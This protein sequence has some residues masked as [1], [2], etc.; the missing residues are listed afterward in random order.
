MKRQNFYSL[1]LRA[2]A[3]ALLMGGVGLTAN[4]QDLVNETAGKIQNTG[5][6]KFKN[7]GAKFTN[8]ATVSNHTMDDG[9][10]EFNGASAVYD[11]SQALGSNATTNRFPGLVRW[12]GTGAQDLNAIAAGSEYYTDLELASAGAKSVPDAVYVGGT[13]NVVAA[14]GD[15]TYAGTFYY[16]GA[17]QR[18]FPEVGASGTTNQYNN[19]NLQGTGL[20]SLN[21]GDNIAL[22][23]TLENVA[24]APL[25]IGGQLTIGTTATMADVV[26]I[27]SANVAALTTSGTGLATFNANL[28]LEQGN[29]NV[30]A[31]GATIST[32]ATLAVA[33]DAEAKLNVAAASDLTIT[34]TFTNAFAAATNLNFNATS[35]TIYNGA[36]SQAIVATV[37]TN[38]YGNLTT[39]N[40]GKT[41]AGTSDNDIYVA[42]DL[43]VNGGDLDVLTGDHELFMTDGGASYGA[44]GYEVRGK[45][46]RDGS[47][48]DNTTLL[49]SATAYT[50]NNPKTI[51]QFASG[52]M[53]ESF[54]IDARAGTAPFAYDNTTDIN[55]KIVTS[56]TG[57]STDWSASIQAGYKSSDIPGTW[58]PTTTEATLRYMES[59][60]DGAPVIEKLATGQTYTREQAGPDFNSITLAGIMPT[61]DAIDGNSDK[62][63]KS[64]NDLLLRGGPT[65]FYAVSSG[66]WSNPG[67]WDEGE[68]P[69]ATDIAV[70]NGYTVHAGFAGRSDGG[71]AAG[72]NAEQHPDNLAAGI[73]IGGM[74]STPTQ[75]GS[76]LIF[77]EVDAQASRVA[78]FSMNALGTITNKAGSG[79]A[80]IADL[81]NVEVAD[82][83][84]L[85]G[86]IIY[87][88]SALQTN[89]LVNEGRTA[90]GGE[91]EIGD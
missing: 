35:N 13:Y 58:L 89:N 3:V 1:A 15:R 26:T 43:G 46:T 24:G 25:T 62:F 40:S 34:G 78:A 6:I 37:G 36:T 30:E 68:Q 53:P 81:E 8:N 56:Y 20:K 63:I 65:I 90:N 19:L 82:T 79:A 70:I 51:V 87:A 10:V 85:E 52:T 4:A 47:F 75:A 86:L 64:G 41:V 12:N 73:Y 32:G 31:G 16:D 55:R 39:A 60:N 84:P 2:S 22:K 45:M 21:Q 76:G 27:D 38:P 50:Y 61:T 74:G 28:N 14:T 17:A 59:D 49:A 69:G 67:T 71:V 33:N 7:N 29:F 83:D 18:I 5:T 42:G 77:A 23:G 44:G 11:G 88:G 72:Q 9:T 80:A 57:A 48:T 91:L 54:S 66:R